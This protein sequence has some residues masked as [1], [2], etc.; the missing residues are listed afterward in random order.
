MIFRYSYSV[1][2][3]SLDIKAICS[4]KVL[5]YDTENGKDQWKNEFVSNFGLPLNI[6]RRFQKISGQVD[7]SEEKICERYMEAG[8]AVVKFQLADPNVLILK[9]QLRST[10]GEQFSSVGMTFLFVSSLHIFLAFNCYSYLHTGGTMGLFT[11]MSVISIFEFIFW[12]LRPSKEKPKGN[13]K[14]KANSPKKSSFARCPTPR[15]LY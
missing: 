11:G 4:S 2:T 9:K 7:V 14:I 5:K 6:I 13:I 10:V 1:E 15:V 12:M 3:K 8:I